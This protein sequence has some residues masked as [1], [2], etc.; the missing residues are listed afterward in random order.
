MWV[1][2]GD[3]DGLTKWMEILGSEY[4]AVFIFS[5]KIDNI[6]VDYDGRE[7]FE[8]DSNRYIFLCIRL[9]D[10]RKF[11]KQRSPKW[12]TVTLPA[13]KFRK[14]VVKLMDLFK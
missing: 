13:D 14:C 8:F 7:V 2:T 10:Y 9:E 11:M 3:I 4:K 6:D 12:K 5:Y 1:T